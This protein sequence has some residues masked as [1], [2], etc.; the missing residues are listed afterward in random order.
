MTVIARSSAPIVAAVAMAAALLAAPVANA[1][2]NQTNCRESGAAQICQRQGHSS[3]NAKPEVR[4]GS[5]QLFSN[6]W[7]P[8]Y[9]RGHLPPIL[10]LD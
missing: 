7:L 8:G 5:G 3:L 4:S 2:S 6:P 10:A 9:G 1:T